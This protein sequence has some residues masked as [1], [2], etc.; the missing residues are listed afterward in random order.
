MICETCEKQHTGNYASGRFC[1]EIC[2]RSFASRKSRNERNKKISKALKGRTISQNQPPV[3]FCEFCSKGFVKK[4]SLNSHVTHCPFNPKRVERE[5][6]WLKKREELML[7][8]F[9]MI[10]PSLIRERLLKEQQ[11][12]CN[13]CGLSEWLGQKI[14]FELEHKNGDHYDNSRLNIELLCPNCHSM[15]DTWRGRNKNKGKSGLRVTDEDLM[16]AIASTSTIRQALIKV[17]LAAKGGNYV[18]AKRI[19]ESMG[20]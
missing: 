15:T 5:N 19:K 6:R 12:C 20:L 17:K 9:E 14:T 7:L 16:N 3:H 1:S 11:G 13:R 8:P 2:A 4:S 18:R 10:P